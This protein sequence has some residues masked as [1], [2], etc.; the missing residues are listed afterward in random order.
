MKSSGKSAHI[1]IAFF[2]S[3]VSA[4]IYEMTWLK[5]IQLV[6]GHSIYALGTTVA[7]YL[8][9]L[10]VG[11]LC[12]GRI[13]NSFQGPK[14][15]FKSLRFYT[16]AEIFI[17]VYGL[18]FPFLLKAGVLPYQW[19]LKASGGPL[20]LVIPL[21]IIWC[22]SL[23]FIPTF[24]MGTTLPLLSN[25]LGLRHLP[26][27]YGTNAFGGA[28]GVLLT[29]FFLLPNFGQGK[30]LL[31]A[32]CINF[33][34]VLVLAFYQWEV[35]ATETK[36]QSEETP[37]EKQTPSVWSLSRRS[38]SAHTFALAMLFVSGFC[39]MTAQVLWNRMAALVYGSSVYIFPLVTFC[40]LS[41][42]ALGGILT[43]KFYKN[44]T[45]LYLAPLIAGCLFLLSTFALSRMPQL[46]LELHSHFS[47][48]GFWAWTAFEIFT[49]TSA[50]LPACVSLGMLY[51]LVF[52]EI[53]KS[54]S[55]NEAHTSALVGVGTVVNLLGV[56]V[57]VLLG[58][59]ILLP[60]LG[61]D[62]LIEL[63][64]MLLFFL[65]LFGFAKVIREKNSF[66]SLQ[67]LKAVGLAFS[68]AFFLFIP[69]IDWS[70]LTSG[71]FYNRFPKLSQE[72][73]RDYGFLGVGDLSL[74]RPQTVLA[75]QDDP[76]ATVSIH[77]AGINQTDIAFKINGK[78]DG[79]NSSD[80]KTTRFVSLLPALVRT[81]YTSALTV[82]LGVGSTVSETLRFPLLRET[83]VVELSAAMIEFA[84]AYFPDING[85]AW[86]SPKFKVIQRDGRDY[87]QNSGR[88]YDL[89]VSEPSNPWVEGVSSL[90]TTEYYESVAARLTERGVASLWFHTYGLDCIA[91]QSV[92]ASVAAVFPS[93]R[94]FAVDTDLYI[95]AAKNRDGLRFQALPENLAFM[96]ED[97]L[98][99]GAGLDVRGD[100]TGENYRK[101]FKQTLVMGDE[102]FQKIVSHAVAN[103][104]D[105]GLLEFRSGK[106]FFQK[107]S[108]KYFLPS[109]T[110]ERTGQIDQYLAE[111]GFDLAAEAAGRGL[112]SD[113]K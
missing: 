75:H 1:L 19:I 79:N 3:G 60:K 88:Q 74:V 105:N 108:C 14:R 16:L 65:S 17:G 45:D 31:A 98:H 44:K 91:V 7:A 26:L 71:Y 94:V 11:A 42:V 38:F 22:A 41:G 111:M 57:G 76:H 59:F 84:K 66:A 4:L 113:K 58:A 50:L 2:L 67:S 8:G 97:L 90:F 85:K 100:V 112:A 27:L 35:G 61:L 109:E 46:V 110:A 95:L 18:F 62:R 104:D 39:A 40:I 77:A 80:L 29:G 103:T 69:R 52:L 51:P 15:A 107:I 73:L 36:T 6:M 54:Q 49:L 37:F 68:V 101:F 72:Q 92:L 13:T 12:A 20:A 81:D 34:A 82:G 10:A 32:A 23:V 89:I 5:Q 86:R 99:I 70:L 64:F 28:I 24:L 56:I 78:V 33:L 102:N 87:L 43:Q 93:V 106:T 21:Q 63:N 55:H 9:G 30:S 48:V 83:H 53:S 96:R 25:V 47:A